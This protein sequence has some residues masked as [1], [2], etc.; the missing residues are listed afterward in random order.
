MTIPTCRGKQNITSVYL[1]SDSKLFRYKNWYK[2]R[3]THSL[4]VGGKIE[5]DLHN[6]LM[7]LFSFSNCLIV[8]GKNEKFARAFWEVGYQL[9]NLMLQA[10]A[11]ELAFKAILLD[12][13]R[14]KALRTVG[15]TDPV[16]AFLLW[17]KS[18]I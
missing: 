9:L 7:V 14:I 11:L 12:K 13:N 8:I 2:N 3:P 17:R 1:I 4:D 16:S 15:I 5:I 6:E 18:G 10:Q